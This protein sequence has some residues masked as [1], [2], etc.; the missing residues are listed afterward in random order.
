[1]PKVK[2]S[3]AIRLKSIV[4]EFGEDAFSSDGSIL[5][6]KL[7][8]VKVAAEKRFTVQ[9]HIGREK[10]K[11]AVEHSNKQ[12]KAQLLLSQSIAKKVDTS[13]EFCKELCDVL[14]SANIPLS[15]INNPELKRFLEHHMRRS[16]PEESTL[17]KN[18]IPLCYD[19]TMQNIKVCQGKENLRFH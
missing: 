8:E 3:D 10:H 18:Y 4:S 6:C 13:S 5:F 17:G 14:V 2:P 1:M 16:L 9:Q 15:K 7:C 12:K 11:R 19:K